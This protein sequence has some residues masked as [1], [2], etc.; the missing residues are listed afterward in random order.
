MVYQKSIFVVEGR[1]LEIAKAT[2]K[3]FVQLYSHWGLRHIFIFAI[4]SPLDSNL[5]VTCA[6]TVISYLR[7]DVKICYTILCH[8]TKIK[9]F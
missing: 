9:V 5:A 7:S 4:I 8:V 3:I 1:A 6:T 2:D